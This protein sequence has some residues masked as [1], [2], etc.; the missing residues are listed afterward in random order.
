MPTATPETRTVTLAGRNFLLRTLNAGDLECLRDF[1][2]SHTPE[3]I[4]SRY[5]YMIKD[6]TPERA[7]QL[8]CVDQTHDLALGIFE[9]TSHNGVLHA[10]GRYCLDP[11]GNS[12]EA[13]FV[14]RETMR[15]FGMARCLLK[16]LVTTAKARGLA[17][18]WANT[19]VDNQTM[20]HILHKAGFKQ[21]KHRTD[22][23]IVMKLNLNQKS[24]TPKKITP[25]QK[26]VKPSRNRLDRR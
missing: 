8:V 22:G 11:S 26:A 5:G 2:Y 20:L 9:P 3:T 6:M 21:E 23:T 25:R 19:A 13:A 17:Q 10:V 12:A 16:T 4:Q 7:A 24:V 14:V 1:F 15:N 18:L